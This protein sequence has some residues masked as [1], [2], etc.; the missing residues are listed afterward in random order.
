MAWSALSGDS[1][2]LEE[3]AGGEAAQQSLRFPP[4]K[5]SAW[6]QAAD[7]LICDSSGSQTTAAAVAFHHL[8]A[9]QE[10]VPLRVIEKD[11]RFHATQVFPGAPAPDNPDNRYPPSLNACRAVL[12]VPSLDRIVAWSGRFPFTVCFGTPR[13]LS[14]NL[15]TGESHVQRHA[16]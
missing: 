4:E 7:C 16:V 3:L 8:L 11:I 12:R 10:G 5:F 9:V 13:P 14:A 6:R 15:G 1:F 2:Q